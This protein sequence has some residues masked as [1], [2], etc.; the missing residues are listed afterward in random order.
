MAQRQTVQKCAYSRYSTENVHVYAFEAVTFKIKEI[1][2]RS[3]DKVQIQ[4][5]FITG[6]DQLRVETFNLKEVTNS[7][8]SRRT[9]CSRRQCNI[10]VLALHVMLCNFDVLLELNE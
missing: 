1:R 2:P 8:A 4:N 6:S 9:V 10:S 7:T 3:A 5:S